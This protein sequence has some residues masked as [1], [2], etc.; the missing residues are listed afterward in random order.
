MIFTLY[1]CVLFFKD[2]SEKIPIRFRQA[3]DYQRKK[4][5]W[6]IGF[7]ADSLFY[8]DLYKTKQAQRHDE[9]LNKNDPVEIK[10]DQR[11]DKT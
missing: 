11:H 8:K 10:Q 2:D 9:N 1:V 4:N 5:C 7:E 3:E 6:R